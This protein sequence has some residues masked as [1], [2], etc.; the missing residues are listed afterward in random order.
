M[1]YPLLESI[2]TFIILT[3]FK[4]SRALYKCLYKCQEMQ[5]K[6]KMTYFYESRQ[7]NTQVS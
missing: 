7:L 5:Q 4:I 2:V 6:P 1:L 3:N